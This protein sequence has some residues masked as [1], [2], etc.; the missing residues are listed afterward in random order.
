ME[1][2]SIQV[3]EEQDRPAI[4]YVWS[5]G[6]TPEMGVRVCEAVLGAFRQMAIEAEIERRVRES[7]QQETSG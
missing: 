2:I 1:I 6:I 7:V 3:G 4:N 5:S